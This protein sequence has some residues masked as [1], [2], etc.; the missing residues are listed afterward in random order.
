MSSSHDVLTAP[1]DSDVEEEE[2]LPDHLVGS[3]EYQIVGIRYYDGVAHPGEFVVLVREPRNRELLIVASFYLNH[4]IGC[5]L[6]GRITGS[7]YI[8][9]GLLLASFY[10]IEW[11]N[12]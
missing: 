11:K 12:F 8:T 2:D 10:L 4:L 3:G 1:G 9:S 5:I 6:N 7:L